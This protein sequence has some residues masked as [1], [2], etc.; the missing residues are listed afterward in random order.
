MKNS[1]NIRILSGPGDYRPPIPANRETNQYE[2]DGLGLID[3][4]LQAAGSLT[5]LLIH[6]F[7]KPP[8]DA[9]DIYTGAEKTTYVKE[10]LQMSTTAVITGRAISVGN[11][12][13][14]YIAHVSKNL[15]WAKWQKRDASFVVALMIAEQEVEQYRKS[16]YQRG[17]Q[18]I[19]PQ[20]IDKVLHPATAT[21]ATKAPTTASMFGGSSGT[22]IMVMVAAMGATALMVELIN[23][24]NS[25]EIKP[26]K[27]K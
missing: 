13:K 15:N 3:E 11:Q 25:I 5:S 9:W 26:L 4:I 23:K 22:I 21:A 20:M 24:K 8:A 6:V 19:N 12:F 18:Y 14:T 27:I 10:A 17:M 2:T 7:K 1:K 16:G